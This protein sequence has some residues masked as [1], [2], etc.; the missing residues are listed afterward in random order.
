MCSLVSRKNFLKV[1][2]LITQ[3]QPKQKLY[4]QSVTGQSLNTTMQMILILIND[5][6]DIHLIN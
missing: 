2:M 3:V 4:W 1:G 6:G 5:I